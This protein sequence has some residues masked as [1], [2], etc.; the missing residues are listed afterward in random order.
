MLLIVHFMD[1]AAIPLSRHNHQGQHF[2]CYTAILNQRETLPDYQEGHRVHRHLPADLQTRYQDISHLDLAD[3][4]SQNDPGTTVVLEV[5]VEADP[6]VQT[7]P[8]A[9]KAM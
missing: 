4:L 1:G 8:T 9:A 5:T 6:A 7:M 2:I 3:Q